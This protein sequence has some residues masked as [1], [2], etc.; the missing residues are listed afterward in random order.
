MS[1]ALKI[2]QDRPIGATINLK[3]PIRPT[4]SHCEKPLVIRHSSKP[5]ILIDLNENIQIITSYYQ[6][7]KIG[8][9]GKKL[10]YLKS[11]NSYAPLK[12]DYTF[13]VYAKIC[14]FRWQKHHTYDEVCSEMETIYNIRISRTTVE[15]ALKIYEIGCSDKYLSYYQEQIRN[16]GGIIVT[17]DGMA[18]LKGNKSLY[19]IYDYYTGLTLGAKRLPNQSADTIEEFLRSIKKKIEE[20]LKVPVVGLI[21][22]ALPAQRIAIKRVFPKVPHCLCHFHF[23]KLI[24]IDAHN[25]DSQLVTTIRKILR[26]SK[27]ISQFK[28]QTLIIDSNQDYEPFLQG[29]LETIYALSNW[30]RTPKDPCFSGVVLYSRL[31]DVFSLFNNVTVSSTEV[32]PFKPKKTLFTR[33]YHLLKEILDQS[34]QIA[35]ELQRIQVNLNELSGI[36]S[37]ID[38]SFETGLKKLRKFRD[39][40]RR[41][42]LNPSCGEIEKKFIED[43]MKYVRT[44]GKML[45][46]FKKIED[47]PT[48]NNNHE[49]KYKQ[50]KHFLRRVIG[51][52]SA[53]RYLL[54][55]GERIVFIKMDETLANIKI[56][57]QNTDF[58]A[59]RKLIADER[60]P[61]NS[62]PNLMHNT[63]KWDEKIDQ[64]KQILSNFKD[65]LKIII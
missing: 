61:R 5:K 57:L 48:T 11:K 2:N 17:I 44:K 50:L 53:K 45:F 58:G 7:N 30:K 31:N 28:A 33:I 62:L 42:R 38:S 10:P 56:I 64:L 41:Y 25:Q 12:S 26:K 21:S 16:Q 20:Q 54:S 3:F 35:E 14:E 51:F 13:L 36:L 39:R 22:D 37:D 55:H 43:L 15:N 29:I 49:L 23:F 6:C 1:T 4:C 46:N 40:L 27:V 34:R 60:I 18:P 32:S 9:P 47:A 65:P 8:C 59:A 19:V 63:D 52:A 24:L